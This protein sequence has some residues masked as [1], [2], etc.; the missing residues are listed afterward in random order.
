MRKCP[1]V[2]CL[3]V[4][5]SF[6]FFTANAQYRDTLDIVGAIVTRNIPYV[7]NGLKQQNFDLY[8]PDSAKKPMPLIIWI[9]GGGWD[10]GYKGW[11][12]I[13]Y[14]ARLGYAIVSVEYRFSRVAPFPA[15]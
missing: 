1:P 9:H 7:Q 2:L 3:V 14:L 15:Q 6:K 10:G 4:L 5:L 12:E 11:I 13:P 8:I